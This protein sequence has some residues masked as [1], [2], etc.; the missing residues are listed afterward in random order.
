MQKKIYSIA[1]RIKP[2]QYERLKAELKEQ[3]KGK[4]RTKPVSYH[5]QDI[6]DDY[7][8]RIDHDRG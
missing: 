7:F 4:R 1:V 6:I 8:D 5:V 3:S 2:E